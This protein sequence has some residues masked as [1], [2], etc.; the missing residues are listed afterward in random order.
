MEIM[1]ESASPVFVL[2]ADFDAVYSSWTEA[3]DQL[4]ARLVRA[5]M[6]FT[7]QLQRISV[8]LEWGLARVGE[9]GV[10]VE[11]HRQHLL[12]ARERLSALEAELTGVRLV[13][14]CVCALLLQLCRGVWE[15]HF[16]APLRLS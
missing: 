15:L 10:A 16:G 5:C 9:Q 8:D 11:I 4:R 6:G 14:A 3:L 2:Q 1:D 7:E 12:V 13:L